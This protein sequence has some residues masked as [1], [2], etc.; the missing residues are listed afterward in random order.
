MEDKIKRQQELID[1]LVNI[2]YTLSKNTDKDF[3][4]GEKQE[5]I[6]RIKNY[7]SLLND[8]KENKI[9]D[10]ETHNILINTFG[11]VVT[12]VQIML[13]LPTE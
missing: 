1:K 12:K 7:F 6:T 2:I 10:K 5:L 3:E 11:K 8:L 4:E 13:D 9:I